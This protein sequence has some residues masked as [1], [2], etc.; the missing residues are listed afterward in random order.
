MKK[1]YVQPLQELLNTH[2]TGAQDYLEQAFTLFASDLMQISSGV[3][4]GLAVTNPSGAL[5]NI[6]IGSIFQGGVF[7]Q[8]ESTSG[9][10]VAYPGVGTRT[11]LV[12]ASYIEVL[13]TYATGYV[14][15][16]VTTRLETIQ[17]LP[18]RK[19][20]AVKIELLTSTTANTCPAN[21]IPLYEVT[22][23]TSAITGIVDT[24]LF[25]KIQRFVTDIQ[26]D[27]MNLWYS[28]F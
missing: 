25:A 14:L 10:V 15:Q 8:L 3:I 28:M 19:F 17:N 5:L 2:V 26:Q 12:V 9:L 13:D 6:S 22:S 18:S 21:K 7:G 20:G 16:D 1:L 4:T 24:R 23:S 11:D 27:F